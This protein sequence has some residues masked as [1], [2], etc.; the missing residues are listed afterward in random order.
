[1]L[2]KYPDLNT[3]RSHPVHKYIVTAH[4][5]SKAFLESPIKKNKFVRYS[6]ENTSS[7]KKTLKKYSNFNVKIAPL[8]KSPEKKNSLANN[9][10][11]S[12]IPNW[13]TILYQKIFH[14]KEHERNLVATS[15]SI[16]PYVKSY[17][18]DVGRP[19]IIDNPICD[20]KEKLGISKGKE[21]KSKNSL[22]RKNNLKPIVQNSK[23]AELPKSKK[24]VDLARILKKSQVKKEVKEC[25]M[26]TNDLEYEYIIVDSESEGFLKS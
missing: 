9:G 1:M 3:I 10:A 21:V 23:L 5:G 8:S 15:R 17:S 22:I 16:V 13:E 7:F 12:L 25:D 6:P 18:V 2:D 20:L 4:K 11:K 14:R 19:S 26:Q 24:V